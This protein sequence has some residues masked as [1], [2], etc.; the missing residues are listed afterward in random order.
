MQAALP[1]APLSDQV[2]LL[3][4]RVLQGA[5]HLRQRDRAIRGALRP[6]GD[7]LRAHRALLDAVR[8]C[9]QVI[10][11]RLLALRALRIVARGPAHK[12]TG[13]DDVQRC[14]ERLRRYLDTAT[15]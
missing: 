5:L 1:A 12:R 10:G 14:S 4:L 3:A 7:A 6:V 15:E 11:V 8:D 2:F 13:G 9:L